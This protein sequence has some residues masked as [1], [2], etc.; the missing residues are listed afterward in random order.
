MYEGV[1]SQTGREYAILVGGTSNGQILIY[2]HN[3]FVRYR[4]QVHPSSITDMSVD[5]K[6]GLLI[7]CGADKTIR[8]SNINPLRREIIQQVIVIQTLS[9]VPKLISLL[10]GTIAVATEEGVLHMYQINIRQKSFVEIPDHFRSDDHVE[11]ITCIQSIPMLDLFVTCSKDGV[12]KVWDFL[13]TLVREVY[14]V[15]PIE[16]MAVINPW[17]DLIFGI[18]GRVDKLKAKFCLHQC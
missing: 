10:H 4:M 5:R 7:T 14:F 2:G 18:L 11:P 8:V 12:I 6:Q 1:V 16:A 15:E 9:F 17:G 13:N 3:G